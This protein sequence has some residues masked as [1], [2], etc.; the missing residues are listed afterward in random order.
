MDR[1]QNDYIT[2]ENFGDSF[3]HGKPESIYKQCIKDFKEIVS[4]QQFKELVQSFNKNVESFQLIETSSLGYCIQYL[5]LDS[6]KEK[7]ICVVFDST[8]NIHRLL[9]KP[10]IIFPKSDRPSSKNLYNMPIKDEWFV[11]WGGKNEFLNYHYV[12]ESQRYAYD[13]VVMKDNQTYK[14]KKMRNENYYAFNKEVVA[15]AD[16]KVVKVINNIIDNVPSEMNELQPAGNYIVIKH[17]N[18][19]YSLLAHFKQYSIMV[20]EGEDVKQG[21]V[22]GLCGNSGNSSEPH[23]HFQVMDSPDIN[24]CKSICIL[25][26][27]GIVPIQDDI[28]TQGT[29]NNN[30][31]SSNSHSLDKFD[32][33]ELAF[34]LTDALLIIP[35]FIGSLFK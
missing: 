34:S 29:P 19:E 3:L 13:L 14:D 16:G 28:V 1:F 31:D 11:F 10:Y 23:I 15:P 24:N 7:V 30:T 18:N 33:A 27:D 9:I 2:P 8:N 26:T 32:K 12:Y 25:F 4:L 35:R 5:W 20:K 6:H 22:V 21:Q 17:F